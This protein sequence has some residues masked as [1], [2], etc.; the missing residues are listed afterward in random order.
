MTATEKKVFDSVEAAYRLH[1]AGGTGKSRQQLFCDIRTN[2]ALAII[3]LPAHLGGTTRFK[4]SGIKWISSFPRKQGQ[5]LAR[6]SAVLTSERCDDGYPLGCIEASLISAT[7]TAASAAL[8]AEHICPNPFEGTLGHNRQPG[9]SPVRTAR[10]ASCFEHWKF[11]RRSV[12]TMR[13]ARRRSTSARG[14]RDQHNTAGRYS[15]HVV[16]RMPYRDASVILPSTTTTLDPY[17]ADEKLLEHAPTIIHLSLR[18]ICV[19]VI[20]RIAKHRR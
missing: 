7:R 4:K 5:H 9:S 3:A 8:A 19:N 17:L 16:W 2:R 12:C 13:T 18:D 11:R 6:A 20:S 1:A 14:L 10:M 15:E